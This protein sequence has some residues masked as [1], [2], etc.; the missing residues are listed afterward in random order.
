MAVQVF[1]SHTQRD[2][3][4]CDI[5]D[6]ACAR[7]GIRAFRSEFEKIK[8][9][10]WET[11]RDAIRKSRALFLLIGKELV[12]AQALPDPLWPYTQN[13]IAYEIGIA[14]QRE[15]DVWVICDDVTI[16]FPVPYLNNYLPVSLRHTEVFDSFLEVLKIYARGLGIAFPDPQYAIE[17]PYTADCKA[18]YNLPLQLQPSSTIICPQCL[19][20]IIFPQ[21]HLLTEV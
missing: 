2:V 14:C 7:V 4:F 10:A 1:V 9:P 12:R 11:I 16:N 19:H 17:C 8:L 6:R 20:E 5:F 21:G 3:E 13:W 18:I 15:I